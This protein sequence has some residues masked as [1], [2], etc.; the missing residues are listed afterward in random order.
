MR[1]GRTRPAGKDISIGR[2]IC[3]RNVAIRAG[4]IV[5]WGSCA[6]EIEGAG[7][8]SGHQNAHAL[9]SRRARSPTPTTS[10]GPGIWS[11]PHT[12]RFPFPGW[13]TPHSSLALMTVR[14]TRVVAT[15]RIGVVIL[16]METPLHDDFTESR[17]VR[18]STRLAIF[19]QITTRD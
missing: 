16:G 13:A 17:C 9:M 4:S 12:A 6:V 11:Q 5:E 8:G 2:G 18:S 10:S 15:L 7:C 1:G 19:K 3:S 14:I